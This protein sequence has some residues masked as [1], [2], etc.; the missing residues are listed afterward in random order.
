MK[1]CDRSQGMPQDLE[2]RFFRVAA[3]LRAEAERFDAGREAAALP[4]FVPPLRAGSLFSALPLPEPLFLPPPEVLFTV[5]QAR[6]SAT[7]LE[8]P[9]FS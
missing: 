2:A 8:T 7:F 3:A 6:F 9:R 4:P 1:S 5:A